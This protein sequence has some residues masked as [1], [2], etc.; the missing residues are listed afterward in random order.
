MGGVNTPNMKHQFE[1]ETQEQ[2]GQKHNKTRVPRNRRHPQFRSLHLP[3]V[4]TRRMSLIQV[5]RGLELYTYKK[6]V[7]SY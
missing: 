6:T 1:I 3:R 7:E 2:K 4:L 5:K